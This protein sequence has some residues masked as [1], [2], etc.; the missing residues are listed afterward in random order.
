MLY[1]K[2]DAHAYDVRTTSDNAV[3]T[4]RALRTH[5]V[6]R[7]DA[8]ANPPA[9]ETQRERRLARRPVV[10]RTLNGC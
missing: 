6:E 9:W 10:S 1:N 3:I 7:K 5:G 8:G 2:P 4:L